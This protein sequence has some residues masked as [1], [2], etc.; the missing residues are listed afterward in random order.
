MKKILLASAALMATTGM[1]A[2]EI[3]FS[4]FARFG[5]GYEEDRAEETILVHRLRLTV[6]G[7]AETDGGVQFGA[8]FRMQGDE[9]ADNTA[10]A[11]SLSGGRFSVAYGGLEVYAANTGGAIDNA[12]YKSGYEIGLE[13]FF[14]QTTGRD[15]GGFGFSSTGAGPNALYATYTI[16]DFIGGIGYD[17]QT[18]GE[19]WDIFLT[20]TMG[21]F[22]G[23]LAYG[24]RSNS[25]DGDEDTVFL[26]L[27]ASFGDLKVGAIFGDEDVNDAGESG[28]FYG[29]SAS[30][31]VSSATSIL[32]AYGDGEGDADTRAYGIGF[33]HDL[34]GSVSL[35]GGVG[36]SKT[37]STSSV[38]K[39]DLG[40]SFS[41]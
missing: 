21:N 27:D 29:V 38:T 11:L 16:G 14:G 15:Y 31:A 22:G 5:L 9:N 25:V 3:K 33:T 6:D 30:Y 20:Y 41:F 32:F 1:A 19:E 36:S 10:D 18:N 8:R 13:S 40:V 24:D 23:T 39:A 37:D 26:G 2:A 28:N 34:G 35:A 12:K 17:D 7:S 4:G